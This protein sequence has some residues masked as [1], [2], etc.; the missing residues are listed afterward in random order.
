MRR[1]WMVILLLMTFSISAQTVSCVGLPESR[2]VIGEQAQIVISG[3][4]LRFLPATTAQLLTIIPNGAIIPVLDGPSCT[5]G[6][7]W[8]QVEY[9]GERGWVAEGD[10]NAYYLAPYIIQRAQIGDIRIEAQPNLVTDI[11]ISREANPLSSQFVFEGYP[12]VADNLAPFI[13]IFDTMPG[14]IRPETASALSTNL[15][16]GGRRFVDLYFEGEPE[17]TEDFSLVYRFTRSLEDGRFID[18]YLPVT[19]PT[20][21]LT[22]SPPEDEEDREAYNTT[23]FEQTADALSALTSDD[24]T[25]TLLQL[26]TLMR[27]LAIDNPIENSDLL[28]FTSQSSVQFDYFPLLA[29][30]ITRIQQPASDT[31]PSHAN[32]IFT[33]YPYGTGN[34][35]L[36]NT[37]SLDTNTI[38]QFQQTLDRQPS[39][40][41]R[42]PI[43][44]R[45]D[46]PTSRDEVMYL[47]FT[48]G[49]GIR[50]I[51]TFE[52][53]TRFY[54]YQGISDDGTQFVSLLLGIDTEN[55]RPLAIF[56]NIVISLSTND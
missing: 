16:T 25:P 26:D 30:N 2:L 42:I 10:N 36:Y 45:D 1:L 53:G 18:G 7:A 5:N 37:A 23:Y 28:T 22:Y 52:D 24:F 41:P 40:P 32:F 44:S 12:V 29:T 54:S 3:S 34:I 8:W 50:Y 11:R 47:H 48:N 31:L 43:P 55:T 33:D 14:E 21:P 56:D 35:C 38:A 13:V 39:R 4:N 51:A 49:N 19:A 20:L 27:S 6:F 9:D 15:D 17:T 46:M